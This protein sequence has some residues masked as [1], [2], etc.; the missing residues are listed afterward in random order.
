M[1]LER[2]AEGERNFLLSD[3]PFILVLKSEKPQN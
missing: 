3:L 2:M 1:L